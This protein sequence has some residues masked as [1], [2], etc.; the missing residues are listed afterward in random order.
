MALSLKDRKVKFGIMG[1]VGA[2]LAFFLVTKVMGG[3]GDGSEAVPSTGTVPTQSAVQPTPSPSPSPTTVLVF[4][5]RDPFQDLFSGSQGKSSGGGTTPP[6]TSPG[7]ST[8]PP[9]TSPG[10]GGTT[11]PP[12]GGGGNGGN[13]QGSS[14]VIGGHSVLLDDVFV[15]QGGVRKAQVDVDGSVYT[16]AAGESFDD[17]FKLVSFPSDT[18]A[19][20][21]FG[22]E[23]FTLCEAGGK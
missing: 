17:N 19:H 7:G 9:P 15:S 3:G 2:L 4:S 5:G 1:A 10:G 23:S 21:V 14:I 12:S 13:E 8:T 22:D 11:P 18:C 20:F 16:V 6:P